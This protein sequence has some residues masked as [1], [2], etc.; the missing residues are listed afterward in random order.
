MSAATDSK[1][2]N[3]FL[4]LP[5]QKKSFAAVLIVTL[6]ANMLFPILPHLGACGQTILPG[7]WL[8][9]SYYQFWTKNWEWK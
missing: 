7:L 6:V 8:A 2:L 3:P 5:R 4:G 1:H 9:G